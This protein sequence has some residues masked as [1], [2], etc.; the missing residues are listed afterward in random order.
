MIVYKKDIIE[1][2][3]A[4]GFNWAMSKKTGIFSQSTM[5]K[6]KNNDTSIS[7]DNLDRLCCILE[8]QPK[9]LIKFVETNE[10]REN[11]ISKISD[12]AV[13]KHENS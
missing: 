11:I 5:K 8:M 9:D 1:E 3:K 2:L 13:D 10:D 12:N 4:I 7:L 6:F